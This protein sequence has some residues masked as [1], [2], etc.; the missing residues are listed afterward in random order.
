[1]LKT[2]SQY[3]IVMSSV[4][5]AIACE[6][7]LHRAIEADKENITL[8]ASDHIYSSAM[9]LFA[10]VTCK[11]EIQIGTVGM[12]HL[13]AVSVP[14]VGLNVARNE[15]EQAHL[16]AMDSVKKSHLYFWKQFMTVEELKMYE[17]GKDIIFSTERISKMLGVPVMA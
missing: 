8:V 4:G 1:M 14:M 16:E 5:G 6:A 3:S 13:P 11:R 9:N 12:A 7:V 17:A 2:S 15:I 10:N